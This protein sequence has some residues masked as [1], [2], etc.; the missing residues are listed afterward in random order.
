MVECARCGNVSDVTFRYCPHCGAPLGEPQRSREQRKT[1]TALFCDLAGST[2][3]GESVDPE[4]LRALLARY[5]ERMRGIVERHGGTVEKFIGDAVM[6][7]FGVPIVHEDDAL[8]ACRAAVEMRDAFAEL[9][10]I[11]RIGVNTGQVVTGT[12]DALATGDAVNVA[13]R[14]EQ[15]AAPGEVLVGEPTLALVRRAVEVE[16]V[17]PLVLKGKAEPVAAHRLLAIREG[18]GRR[19]ATPMVGREHELQGLRDAFDRAVHNRSCQLFT[20]L[21]VAGVGKS[22]LAAE[23][24]AGLDA[25]AV[26]GTCL[27]YGEGIT[28]WPVVEIVKKLD[29]RPGKRIAA[30][31]RSLLGETEEET[32]ADGIAWAFRKLLEEEAEQQPLVVVL[33]DLQ[34][35]E[36]TLLDLVEQVADLSEEAPI[37]LLCMARPELLDLRPSWGGGKWNAATVLLEP[38]DAGESERLL[39]ALGGAEPEL[40]AQI[41]AA[42]EGNPLFLEEML[43]LVRTTAG[44]RVEMPPS[45]QALLAARLDQLDEEERGVLER[46]AVE[47]RVFHEDTVTA[48]AD[49]EPQHATLV[50]LVRKRL[51]RPVT[52]QPPGGEAYRFRHLLI[53]DAAYEG[54]PKT[55]RA[56]LHER[57]AGRLAPRAKELVEA[58]EILGY[59]LEQAARYRQELGEGDLRIAR[60]AATHLAVAGRRALWRG[61]ERAAVN[62]L[63]RALKLTRPALDVLLEVDLCHALSAD[64]ERAMAVAGDAADRAAAAGDDTGAALARSVAAFHGMQSGAYNIDE[65]EARVREALPLVEESGDP[66]AL[67]TVLTLLA[68]VANVRGRYEEWARVAQ[69]G[70][71][72]ARLAG[73]Q[74]SELL[75]FASALAVG[76]LPAEE[77]LHALD[78]LLSTTSVPMTYFRR[79]ELLAMLDRFDEAQLAAERAAELFTAQGARWGDAVYATLAELRGDHEAASR[80]WRIVC[81]WLRETKQNSFL[82]AYASL[83]GIELCRLDRHDEA[84]DLARQAQALSDPNDVMGQAFWRRLQALLESQRGRDDEAERLA[85]EAVALTE[86]TDGLGFQ[87]DALSDLAE[88][89]AG[90]GRADE[91]TAALTL[92]LERYERK[93]NLPLARR[94]RQRLEELQPAHP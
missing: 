80:H 51:L 20:V 78:S 89:L 8:R 63:E 82:S 28:Y 22:R 83:L 52:P 29:G 9:G 75:H 77:G 94:I 79:A 12:D 84:E 65:F 62:L 42:A 17:E 41:T 48:L 47:G 49:G 19:F 11:G 59:H 64:P 46:G 23:F 30:P 73:Q 14:L 61:D 16:P 1:V 72:Q 81:D 92:A 6:A 44:G 43:E 87:G 26:G 21:G 93:G 86:S 40:R 56:D 85:R 91:A 45:I 34:W 67:A 57:L 39:D 69:L 90:A 58:D 55:V 27:P 60:Q 18:P 33:D 74:R 7:V 70:L 37:V 10:I 66:N 68:D 38:L 2:A 76:P 13:A 53:R 4:A 31:L 36:S 71:E 35:G 50:S 54:L 25:R 88:V 3:I 15:A 32:S 24:L 5:F